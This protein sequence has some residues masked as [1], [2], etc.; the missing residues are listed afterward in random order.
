MADQDGLNDWVHEDGHPDDWQSESGQPTPTAPQTTGWQRV[1]QMGRN[2]LTSGLAEGADALAGP[3]MG[4]AQGLANKMPGLANRMPTGPS[5]NG[6]ES[7]SDMGQQALVNP[8]NNQ[9]QT[10]GERYAYEGAKGLAAAAPLALTGGSALST[11]LLSALGGVAGQAAR[12]YAPGVPWAPAAAGAAVGSFGALGQHLTD[13]GDLAKVAAGLGKSTTL[14][15]AGEHVQAAAK[16]WLEND[17]PQHESA[18]WTPVDNVMKTPTMPEGPPTPPTAYSAA[19]NG[20]TS[21]GGLLAGQIAKISPGLPGQLKSD[22]DAALSGKSNYGPNSPNATI[23]PSWDD[24]RQLRTAIGS[25]TS[26]PKIAADIGAKNIDK[27]YAAITDDLSR[28]AAMHGAGDLFAQ[29]NATSSQLRTMADQHIKPLID[30]GIPAQ[31]AAQMALDKNQGGERLTALRAAIPNSVGELAAAKL[32]TDPRGYSK[33]PPEAQAQLVR[34][35]MMKIQVDNAIHSALGGSPVG[36]LGH[37]LVAGETGGSIGALLGHNF[38]YGDIPGGAA[39]QL[40]GLA[41]RKALPAAGAL[42]QKPELLRPIGA[43][44]IGSGGQIPTMNIRPDQ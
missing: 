44:W 30:N 41:L 40:A 18:V 37:T 38:G 24:M 16:S 22:L 14:Q 7:Y 13:I 20:I 3:V 10:A 17:L 25:L 32:Q 19:L 27:L 29:A 35:P 8:E 4:W 31:K 23:T 36:S 11:T 21:K 5:V 26:N 15:Q 42:A 12:E 39:G 6:A 33:L 9:P 1:V 28:T 2:A 43:G 34:D